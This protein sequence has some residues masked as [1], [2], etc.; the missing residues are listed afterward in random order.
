MTNHIQLLELASDI[1]KYIF[2]LCP[3][4][5]KR[6]LIRTCSSFYEY[7]KLMPQIEKEFQ[8][9]ILKTNFFYTRNFTGFS[10]PLYKYTIELVYD[11]YDHLI[12]DRYVILENRIL[13]Q[14]KRIYYRIGFRGNLNLVQRFLKLKKN[15]Y[16]NNN[17]DFVMRG[18]AKSG[19]KEVLRW[20]KLHKYKFNEWTSACAAKGHQFVL[21]KWLIQHG[22]PIDSSCTAYCARTGN[23]EML[24]WLIKKKKCKVDDYAMYLASYKG[25]IDIVKYLY[26]KNP[27]DSFEMWQG[28]SRGG[29][30]NILQWALEKDGE[31]DGEESCRE[32]SQNGHIHVLKWF[33]ANHL[34]VDKRNNLCEY[35]IWGGNFE[36][37]KWLVENG[38]K[39][40]NRVGSKAVELGDLDIMKWLVKNGCKLG[41]GI[42]ADAAE[43][44]QLEILKWLVEIGYKM[45]HETAS[46]AAFNGHLELLQWAVAN[47]CRMGADVISSASRNGH[48]DLIKWARKNGCRWDATAC[49][50]TVLHNHFDILVWLRANGCPWNELVC[51]DAVEYLNMDILQWAIEN[52]CEWG[53]ETY[54][55]ACTGINRHGIKMNDKPDKRIIKYLN[56]KIIEK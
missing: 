31:F 32:A 36:C 11:N 35:A 33:Q 54:Q 40:N 34:L 4:S 8:Q 51:L 12:P 1:T 22:C 52:G 41:K 49:Q 46:S 6:S 20:M 26:Y 19:N 28:A 15:N 25:H 48:F 27:K 43:H 56:R 21:L 29:H 17:A 3:I 16:L 30:I 42:C 50:H 7:V 55:S 2:L 38:Y 47:G 39:F 53:D 37:L 18:A 9:M 45:S 24:K 44:G 23:L 10:N 14:Y 13:H 5:D